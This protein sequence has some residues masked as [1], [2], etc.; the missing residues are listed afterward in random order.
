MNFTHLFYGVGGFLKAFVA[1]R[2]CPPIWLE[3]GTRVGGRLPAISPE[4]QFMRFNFSICMIKFYH[5]MTSFA[6]RGALVTDYP[7]NRS[8]LS[9]LKIGT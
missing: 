6:H 9:T 7:C 1:H 8:P 5:I 4:L 2:G 3:P